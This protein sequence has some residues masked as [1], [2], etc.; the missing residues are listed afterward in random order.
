MPENRCH[1]VQGNKLVNRDFVFRGFGLAGLLA[2]LPENGWFSVTHA[3]TLR[4][5]TRRSESDLP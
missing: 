3:T 2:F 1:N 5:N 4:A